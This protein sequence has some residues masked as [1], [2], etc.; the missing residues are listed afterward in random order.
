[1]WIWT[2][3]WCI[4]PINFEDWVKIYIFNLYLL[5]WSEWI[6]SN[7]T[8]NHA[9]YTYKYKKNKAYMYKTHKESTRKSDKNWLLTERAN[10][11]YIV[12]NLKVIKR[13][14]SLWGWTTAVLQPSL[15]KIHLSY[16]FST[17]WVLRV[18][19]VLVMNISLICPSGE[20]GE[21]WGCSSISKKWEMAARPWVGNS[22]T[23]RAC[24]FLY[25]KCCPRF[26]RMF[27]FVSLFYNKVLCL[28]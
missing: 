24:Y 3:K 25:W 4:V 6:L 10:S 16:S 9:V 5:W 26:Q 23:T 12:F 21:E 27:N 8:F 15:K 18:N 11:V 13:I 7:S 17:G 20:A 22:N 19:T 28:Q 14:S 2:D 1:M